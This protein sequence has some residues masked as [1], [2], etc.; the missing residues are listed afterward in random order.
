[1]Y[2]KTVGMGRGLSCWWLLDAM[3]A[4]WTRTEREVMNSASEGVAGRVW[5]AGDAIW[6]MVTLRRMFLRNTKYCA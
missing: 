5:Y 6:V 3:R 1:M 2:F 4:A